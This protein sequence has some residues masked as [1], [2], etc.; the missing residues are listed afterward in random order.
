MHVHIAEGKIVKPFVFNLQIEMTR[1]Y[2][3]VHQ[4]FL[5]NMQELLSSILFQKAL[6]MSL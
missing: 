5:A 6:M 3:N 4:I 2:A 1:L